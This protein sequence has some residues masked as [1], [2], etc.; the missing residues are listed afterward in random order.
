[1]NTGTPASTPGPRRNSQRPG[2][3]APGRRS[4]A[5]LMTTGLLATI[6]LAIVASA[7]PLCNAFSRRTGQ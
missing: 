3:R 6:M 2:P 7:F 1:M 4:Y 5:S